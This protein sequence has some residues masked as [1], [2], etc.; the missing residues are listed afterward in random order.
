MTQCLSE[1]DGDQCDL[2]AGHDGNHFHR[3]GVTMHVWS[4]VGAWRYTKPPATP[5]VPGEAVTGG[6]NDP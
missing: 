6:R 1:S 4:R 2:A 3:A 5:S